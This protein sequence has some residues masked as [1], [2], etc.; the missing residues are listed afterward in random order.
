MNVLELLLD[1]EY[2]GDIELKNENNEA[3]GFEQIAVIPLAGDIYAILKPR[4]PLSKMG[5]RDALVFKVMEKDKDPYLEIVTNE[6][7]VNAVF[8]IYG[9]LLEEQGLK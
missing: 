3:I 9:I 5:E 2:S 7:L 4:E 6:G 1:D 8:A